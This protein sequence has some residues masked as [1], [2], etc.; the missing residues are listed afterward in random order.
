MARLTVLVPICQ[1]C[2]HL[3]PCADAD[4]LG[5]GTCCTAFPEGIPDAIYLEGADHRQPYE[6]DGGVQWEQSAE[7]G[8]ADRLA[9]YEAGADLGGR[10]P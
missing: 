4:V 6:G 7:A 3:G 1:S 8:A 9:A 5:L 2:A 10:Q